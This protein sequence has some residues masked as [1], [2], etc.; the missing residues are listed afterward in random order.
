MSEQNYV[1]GLEPGTWYAEGRAEARK[2]GELD[3]IA[4]GE[5]KKFD[6]EIGIVDGLKDLSK[7]KAAE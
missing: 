2:R 1:V 4:P 5:I 7:I 6:V 3:M